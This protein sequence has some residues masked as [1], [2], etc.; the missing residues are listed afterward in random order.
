MLLLEKNIK[1]TIG[2]KKE[3]SSAV[4]GKKRSQRVRGKEGKE[5]GGEKKTFR[6]LP[7]AAVKNNHEFGVYICEYRE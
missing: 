6:K 4:D 7:C 1:R 5:N 3:R 2:T